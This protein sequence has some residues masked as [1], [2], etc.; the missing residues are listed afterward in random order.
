MMGRRYSLAIETLKA[1]DLDSQ[2]EPIIGFLVDKNC[3]ESRT[4]SPAS[5]SKSE[6]LKTAGGY[7]LCDLDNISQENQQF[8]SS[9][10]LVP[11]KKHVRRHTVA[12][13]FQ[14]PH[15]AKAVKV[16]GQP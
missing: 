13:K 9:N 5:T 10:S 11:G 3:F 16:A 14:V 2:R 4:L 12:V 15:S 6:K 7:S 1:P 8:K